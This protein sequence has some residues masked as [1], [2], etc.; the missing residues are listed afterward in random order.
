MG[1][2]YVALSIQGR[3]SDAE[4]LSQR[5]ITVSPAE[6]FG[7]MDLFET[8]LAQGRPEETLRV[9]EGRLLPLFDDPT[10]AWARLHF[11]WLR[12]VLGGDL[13]RATE[14]I[15]AE[16]SL[17]TAVGDLR[18]QLRAWVDAAKLAT[19][20]GDLARAGR[21]ADAFLKREQALPRPSR[22]THNAV[23]RDRV[24]LMLSIAARAG[25]L[26]IEELRLRR[27][28]WLEQFAARLDRREAPFLWIEAY[29]RGAETRAE[30]EEA[31]AHAPADLGPLLSGDE[32]EVE[33]L[34][35]VYVLAGRAQEAIP[36]LEGAARQC[37][38]R[39]YPLEIPR[40]SYFLGL[41]QEAIG[42]RAA[43][44]QAYHRLL[45]RWGSPAQPQGVR[46]VSA[47][48][49]AQRARALGCE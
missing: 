41:A 47:A 34:G 16:Q 40:A 2:L 23:A 4:Q 43:A 42:D 35:R 26:P 45:R 37:R 12:A 48:R 33:A 49:A 8:E 29:A 11:P 27:Q 22:L 18:D 25:L 1:S 3:C 36:L 9:T 6:M 24:P 38:V 31:L 46:S 21:A 20:A 30:A 15:D 28:A 19:E 14:L 10:R 7:Y 5:M 32:L 39:R 44:C 13:A 17:A